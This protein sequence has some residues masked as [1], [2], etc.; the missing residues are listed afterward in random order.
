VA[1]SWPELLIWETSLQSPGSGEPRTGRGPSPV[2][3]AA[4]G[5]VAEEKLWRGIWRGLEPED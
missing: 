1:P 3:T 5:Q 4:G 2:R